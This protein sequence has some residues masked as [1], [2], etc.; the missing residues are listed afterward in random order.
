MTTALIT[1]PATTRTDVAE[2]GP[3][4]RAALASG[5]VAAAATTTIAAV[6]DAAG[7]SFETDGESIPLMGFAQ[8]T[9]LGAL[10]GLVVARLCRRAAHP[11]AMFVRITVALTALSLVPDFTMSFDTASRLVLVIT[12][13]VAAAIVV[14]VLARRLPAAH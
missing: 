7:V 8:M 9:L 2:T 6:A 4:W 1:T 10:L 14:P 11:R 13:V 5:V 3:L 12:H